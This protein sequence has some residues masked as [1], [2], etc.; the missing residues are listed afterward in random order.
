MKLS[1]GKIELVRRGN[2]VVY[3]D[4]DRLVK[5]FNVQKPASDVY[6]EALNVARVQEA[7]VR[8]PHILEVSR[9]DDGSWALSMSFIKGKNLAQLMQ[10]HPE[11]TME[12]LEQFVSLQKELHSI[13]APLLN[14]QKD[15]LTRMVT[16]CK[17]LDATTR[18]DL[19][20]RI[21]GMQSGAKVCHGDYVPSNVIVNEVDGKLYICDWAHVT[22]GLPAVDAAITY[23][24][25]SVEHPDLAEAYL[26][27][28]SRLCDTPRQII[29]YWLPVVAAAELTRKRHIDESHLRRWLSVGDFE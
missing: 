27:C 3:Q 1:D 17:E 7:G 19:Q 21:D 12:Y 6:N 5:V 4:Q 15:K 23:M 10:E 25:M 14:R 9:T 28:Y 8:T 16:A 20:M 2:K 24:L 29:H 11:K 18:Y 13:T 26:E 22:E